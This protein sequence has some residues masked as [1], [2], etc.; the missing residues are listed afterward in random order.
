MTNYVTRVELRGN[1]TADDYQALHDAMEA[2]GFT[3][4]ITSDEGTA[5]KMPHAMYYAV[6]NLTTSQICDHAHEAA[7]S[8]W[9]NCRAFSCEAP[10][11]S[12]QGLDKA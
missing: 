6:S 1:P 2:K 3:R 9:K 11:I 12:W 8:V 7:T 10:R 5:Y 4:T